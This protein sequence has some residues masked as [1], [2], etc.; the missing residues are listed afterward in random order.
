M[1]GGSG[2]RPCSEACVE[3]NTWAIG[4]DSDQYQ[5]YKDGENPEK[6]DVILTSHAERSRQLLC[7]LFHQIEEGDTDS[8]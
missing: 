5:M 1:A 8:I 7:L 3:S 6:A 4:A 2:G